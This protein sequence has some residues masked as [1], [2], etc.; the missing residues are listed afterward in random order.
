MNYEELVIPR[1]GDKI[2]QTV[3]LG[4]QAG[5]EEDFYSQHTVLD[6]GREQVELI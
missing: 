6:L 3:A 4:C 5:T 1:L 2:Y